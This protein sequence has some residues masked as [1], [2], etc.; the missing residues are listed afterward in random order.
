MFN[1]INKDYLRWILRAW[2]YRLIVEKQEINFMLTHLKPGQ[3]AIDIGAHKG[4]YTYWM[5]RYTGADGNVF[6]F[7]PQPSLYNQLNK[8]LDNSKINNVHVELLALSS[9]KGEN[10]LL[11]PGKKTSPSASIHDKKLD[12]G[13]SKKITVKTT[14][15]DDY[16]CGRNQIPVHFIK[17]DVEGHELEVLMSGQ[18]LIKKFQPIIILEL[19]LIHI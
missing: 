13:I 5:S 3:T 6:A 10:T 19:S 18:K 7:E 8:I 2:R 11:M 12:D 14:T 17:C 15:L 1:R 9:I 16:F 4:A